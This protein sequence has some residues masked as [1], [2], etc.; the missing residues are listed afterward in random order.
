MKIFSGFMILLLVATAPALAQENAVKGYMIDENGQPLV[1]A[2][3]VLLEPSDSTMRYFSITGS[4]GSFG[5]RSIRNGKYLMQ[6]SFIGYETFYRSVEVPLK[7][8]GDMGYI[9]L[10]PSMVSLDEVTVKGE[11]IPVRFRDDTVEYDARAFSVKP[12][13]VVED[14]LRKLPGL[15]LDRA[16]N[17]KALGEDVRNV[18]VD[19][20][21]FF[22]SDPK[23]ATKN[24]PANAVDKVQLY[25]KKSEE[26]EFTGIDDGS[27]NQTINLVLE[28]ES[29]RGVFGDITAG[30]GTGEHYMA[31]GKAYRFSEK[32]QA[33]V[34]GMMNNVN[35][36]GFSLSDYIT[37]GGGM[38]AM[39]GG[40]TFVVGGNGFPVN[41][42]ETE[43]GFTES[44]ALGFNYS[45]SPRK[46]RRYF[47]S[48]SGSGSERF[49]HEKSTTTLYSETGS[50]IQNED[51]TQTRRDTSHNLNFGVR[52][53]FN[54]KNNIIINGSLSA[55]S[56]SLP[57]VSETES[58]REGLPV[59]SNS[60]ESSDRSDS[61]SGKAD[62]SFLRK[63]NDGKSVVKVT[64]RGSYSNNGSRSLFSN[65]TTLFD[66]LQEVIESSY[67]NNRT[68]SGNWGG[69]ISFTHQIAGRLYGDITLDAGGEESSLRRRQG[70]MA[71]VP[72]LTD[73]LSP[74]FTLSNRQIRPGITIRRT[75]EKGNLSVGADFT[76]GSYT[77]TLWDDGG[78]GRD[79][80]L[81]Q[82][83]LSWDWEYRTSRRVMVNYRSRINIASLTQLLPV[84]NN[85][86]TL[87]VIYGNRN[88]RPEKIHTA[89]INWMIFDQFSFTSLFTSLRMTYTEDKINY[90]RSVD[91]NLVQVLMPVNVRSDLTAGAGV[92]FST[93]VRFLG[94]KTSLNIDES[95]NRGYNIVNGEENRVSGITH[96]LSLTIENRQKEKWD[97]SSGM[98]VTVSDVTYS[99]MDNLD[100]QYTDFSWFGE[101]RFTPGDF[102]DMGVSADITNY[103]AQSFGNAIVVPLVGADITWSFLKSRRAALTLSAVDLLNRN[104]GIERVAELNYLQ[105]RETNI[106]GRYVMLALKWRLNRIGSAGTTHGGFNVEI[107]K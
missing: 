16:G 18:L 56:G 8:S 31:G 80:R 2:T 68:I 85:Y 95:Y 49:L 58:I 93:P 84:A 27:R 29:K 10:Q 73:S 21:E 24:L 51:N 28:E 75:G 30:G 59:N 90:S 96:R 4:D 7:E 23:L 63:I 79:Y 33:A 6:A 12:D 74:D 35:R 39:S 9:P 104:T 98:A 11:R 20:K 92:D 34:L 94:I 91:E 107:R 81:L 40:G 66:P 38:T 102:L 70:V 83:R 43:K 71:A 69:A 1:S 36:Q 15:E 88:L 57:L 53:L 42:G 99:I 87:S 32:S 62:G 50:F 13:G 100:N 76:T 52:H 41:F 64:G 78:A 25:N 19:G 46:D 60:R 101:I 89:G 44:G 65:T 82:P 26:S 14:L 17:I 72:E 37:F 86:N 48:Y 97:V 54:E 67:R 61:F 22:S 55:G 103:T 3:V 105:Q 106:I 47:A 5:I 45:R 77:T